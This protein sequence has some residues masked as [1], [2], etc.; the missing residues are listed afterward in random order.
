MRFFVMLFL[1]VV[2]FFG[3]FFLWP[4]LFH[5]QI[6]IETILPG[7]VFA[8]LVGL[9]MRVFDG[10]L[11]EINEPFEKQKI[12]LETKEAPAP[13]AIRGFLSMATGFVFIAIIGMVAGYFIIPGFDTFLASIADRINPFK[14]FIGK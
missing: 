5:R 11:G 4:A 6:D 8:A 14:G 9:G 2:A 1:G 7:I 10:W 12:V 3:V 13:I